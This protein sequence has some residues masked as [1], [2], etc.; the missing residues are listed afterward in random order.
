MKTSRIVDIFLAYIQWL[1]IDTLDGVA[2]TGLVLVILQR[3][4]P[5]MGE[6]L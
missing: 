3:N 2:Q 1:I 5:G 4:N 6:K